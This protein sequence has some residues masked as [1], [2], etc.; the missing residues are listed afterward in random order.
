M[1]WCYRYAFKKKPIG[2]QYVEV[3]FLHLVGS[4]VHVVHPGVSVA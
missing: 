1:L 4:A 3:V 2:T